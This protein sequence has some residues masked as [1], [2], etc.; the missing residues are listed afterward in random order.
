VLLA[1]VNR[2]DWPYRLTLQV[3]EADRVSNPQWKSDNDTFVQGVERN[4]SGQPVAIHVSNKHPGSSSTSKGYQWQRVSIRGQSGRRNVIHLM[5]KL[6]PGQTR[7]VPELAPIMALVKQLGRFSD[8]EVD[9]AVNSAA[10][11]IFTK[12]DPEAFQDVFDDSG[13]GTYVSNAMKW[14]GGFK[15]GQAINLLPGEEIQTAQMSRPNPNFEGFVRALLVQIGMALSIPYEVLA[16][17]FNS[18]Y[19]ASKAAMMAAWRTFRIRREW[20]AVKLCQPVYEEWL[21][22]AVASGRISAPGF[23]SDQAIRKAWCGS[24]WSGDGPGAIDPMKEAQAARERMDIGL[25]TLAEEI[26]AFDGGDWEQK[27]IQ[28]VRERSEREE[29]GLVAPV[30]QPLPGAAAP[31]APQEPMQEKDTTN[32]TESED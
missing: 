13:R 21:A 6:R 26:V 5:R 4:E 9:A 28:Q 24:K 16:Q 19:S 10:M 7:G 25:T 12:M 8:A 30:T 11:A 17:Q 22:D 27:H 3:I 14:D 23:F 18:S 32:D 2:K 20:I 31:N 29:G 1:N 15:T